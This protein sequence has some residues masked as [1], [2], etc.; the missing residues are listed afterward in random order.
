[1]T[2]NG[3]GTVSRIAMIS[4]LQNEMLRR[5]RSRIFITVAGE[6][7]IDS[8]L[9]SGQRPIEE[10]IPAAARAIYMA[11]LKDIAGETVLTAAFE[12][13]PAA[14]FMQ[15]H[16]VSRGWLEDKDNNVVDLIV[17]L[18]PLPFGE[19]I[20]MKTSDAVNQIDGSNENPLVIF[21]G[22]EDLY[23]QLDE[24]E[25]G[26]EVE[27]AQVEEPVEQQV[28]TGAS[29]GNGNGNGSGRGQVKSPT[30]GRL[31]VNRDATAM[32]RAGDQGEAAGASVATGA[33]GS[34]ARMAGK[35]GRVARPWDG[36]LKTNR[37][38]AGADA[39]GR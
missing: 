7:P 12:H 1:M 31:K 2:G 24:V 37:F 9:F 35:P 38:N 14:G 8:V 17:E 22:I 20:A 32:A 30:D 15:Q 26:N 5:N 4:P 36:R 6:S 21:C 10:F 29:N 28:D 18:D 16:L 13:T 25:T 3:L 34:T 27:T 33:Q 39:G 23:P 11:G 19:N